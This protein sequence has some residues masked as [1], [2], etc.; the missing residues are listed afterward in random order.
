MNRRASEAMLLATVACACSAPQQP[1]VEAQPTARQ[2]SVVDVQPPA[3]P[4]PPVE[5]ARQE[6]PAEVQPTPAVNVSGAWV[7]RLS[8]AIA[9]EEISYQVCMNVPIDLRQPGSVTYFDG[10]SCGGDIRHLNEA[11]G[12]HTFIENLTFGNLANGGECEDEGRI[13]ARLHPDG[14]LKWDWFPIDSNEV[15]VGGTLR[16]VSSCP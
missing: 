15:Q 8:E 14:S 4:E 3:L 12:L 1:R 13:E 7:G 9:D 5:A 2:V 16:R 11:G 10:L 6:P